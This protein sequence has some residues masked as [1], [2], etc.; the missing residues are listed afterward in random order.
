MARS[1]RQIRVH[2]RDVSDAY[3]FGVAGVERRLKPFDSRRCVPSH[4]R[5]AQTPD[6]MHPYVEVRVCRCTPPPAGL[7]RPCLPSMR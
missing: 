1:M 7:D 3:L 2:L 4:A 6:L 5:A